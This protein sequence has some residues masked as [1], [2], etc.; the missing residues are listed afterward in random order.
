MTAVTVAKSLGEPADMRTR[1]VGVLGAV[2]LG[3]SACGSASEKVVSQVRPPVPINVTVY[4]DDARVS[5]SPAA[6]GAGP[7]TFIVTNQASQAESLT[8]SRSGQ[9]HPLASTAPINPLGA[10]Q[11]AVDFKPGDYT[12]ATGTRGGTDAT[13]AQPSSIQA[14]SIHIGRERA[15]SS[16][17]LLEP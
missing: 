5:V 3:V 7:V 8:I 16:G 11:V 10:T 1:T 12:I 9:A 13:L 2:I 17:T 14:A 6:T 15:N 4:V